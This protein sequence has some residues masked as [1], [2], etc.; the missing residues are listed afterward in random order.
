MH[1]FSLLVTIVSK[2]RCCLLRLMGSLPKPT[3]LIKFE[4]LCIFLSIQCRRS[5]RNEGL[6]SKNPGLQSELL[7]SAQSRENWDS[8]EF[9]PSV[10]NINI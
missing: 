1:L 3:C 7:K 4:K 8:W 6:F 2:C 5:K 10:L 9:I